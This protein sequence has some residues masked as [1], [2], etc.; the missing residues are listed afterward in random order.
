MIRLKIKFIILNKTEFF[1]KIPAGTKFSGKTSW[2]KRYHLNGINIFKKANN[3]SRKSGFV[4]ETTTLSL[5]KFF[6]KIFKKN[7]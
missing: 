2:T 4:P 5:A 1:F 3:T 6:N 7:I